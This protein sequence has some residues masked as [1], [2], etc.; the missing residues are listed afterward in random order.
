[1]FV[2]AIRAS[3]NNVSI[4]I[5]LIY[6]NFGNHSHEAI[7]NIIR[8]RLFIIPSYGK[9]IRY[10]SKSVSMLPLHRPPF[11]PQPL[12]ITAWAEE[13]R[14][15]EK[16]ILKGRQYLSDAE[17][18]AIL[19][20]SGS[21]RDSAVTLAQRLLQSAGHDLN[22]LAKLSRTD[23]S[24]FHGI[25]DAKAVRIIAALELGRRKQQTP[26]K[27]YPQMRSS[28]DAYRILHPLLS[29][30]DHEECWMLCLNQAN[31]IMHHFKIS[32]GGRSAT[33]VDAK[34]IFEKALEFKA[35]SIVLAHNHP[36]N[37]LKPSRADHLLTRKIYLAGQTLD[38][39]L[40]DHLIITDHAFYSFL[41]EGNFKGYP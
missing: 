2:K 23:L 12:A 8:L 18:L 6:R 13:D 11:A 25:G 30:L 14:P 20:G 3:F 40:I 31:R 10:V 16:L 1:M 35:S 38:I 34:L 19:I 5:Y 7:V 15:R 9:R 4:S 36:S 17:L 28:S 22:Q 24:A 21:R 37:N 32:S 26:A 29:E 33:V 39:P 41:D 27:E